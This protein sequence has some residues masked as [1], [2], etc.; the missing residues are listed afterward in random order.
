M[1]NVK[2]A[3]FVVLSNIL[4]FF[5]AQAYFNPS[6]VEQKPKE[7]QILFWY[8]P[9]YPN[10]KF[11]APGP[12]PFM[13]MDLV[14]KYAD[15]EQMFEGVKIDPVQTQNL[16]LRTQKAHFGNLVFS[17]SAS[18]NLDYNN[19]SL[20]IIQPRADGFVEKSYAFNAGDSVKKG[21]A[22]IDITVPEWVEAQSEYLFSKNKS[23]LERLRLLGM[24]RE[25]IQTLQK[26]LKIQTKFTIKS[27]IDGVITAYDLRDGMNFSKDKIVAVIQSVSPIWINAFVPESL[28][29]FINEKSEFSVYIPSLKQEF[30]LLHVEVLPSV[31]QITKTLN[32]R[33]EID[34]EKGILKPGMNAYVNI[35]TKSDTM[36]LIP[37][38]AV[39]DT[40]NEQRVITVGDNKT[41]V[42]K[43]IKILGESNGFTAV[44]G[45]N[46]NESVVQTGV[47]LIDS[48]AD[49]A[50]AL[51]RM[52]K[53]DND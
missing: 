31:N 15:E 1:R 30:N 35:K 9:M 4:V 49:I 47:F 10:T 21:D 13:D 37:S 5:A 2:I 7:L 14:P 17:Q 8:D 51:D 36:L 11:D 16:A 20:V 39:I 41:F 53:I 48:E 38:S 42:P 6:H 24:P 3:A 52:R 18:A 19:H 46:E 43:L 28:T 29:S 44:L 22:L 26:T 40:G 33:A 23:V 25:A 32:L 27:P 50:G 45:L 34:N 12:S